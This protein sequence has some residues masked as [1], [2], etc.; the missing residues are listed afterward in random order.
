MTVL[1]WPLAYQS[2][3]GREFLHLARDRL[4]ATGL[5]GQRQFVSD[6]LGVL[7]GAVHQLVARRVFGGRRDDENLVEPRGRQLLDKVLAQTGRIG[8]YDGF[9]FF[10][11][12]WA[13]RVTQ[14]RRRDDARHPRLVVTHIQ[15]LVVDYID[16]VHLAAVVAL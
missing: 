11:L 10:F 2:S 7:R 14:A 8:L 9:W 5:D 12:G 6:A 4:L 13:V 1:A 3:T 15:V 16:P